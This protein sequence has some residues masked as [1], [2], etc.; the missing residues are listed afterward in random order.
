ME[1]QKL[2]LIITRIKVSI[3]DFGVRHAIWRILEEVLIGK[4]FLYRHYII[5]EKNLTNLESLRI[6]NKNLKF[7]FVSDDDI[8]TLQKIEKMSGLSQDQVSKRLRDCGDCLVAIDNKSVAGVNLITYGI[9]YCPYLHREFAFSESEA[10][11]EQ[12][13]VAPN[14]RRTGI[15]SDLRHIIFH[16]LNNKGYVRLIGGYAPLN[17]R[18]G[19][20]ARKLGFVEREKITYI[21]ILG[22][23]KYSVQQLSP[24]AEKKHSVKRSE[25]AR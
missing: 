8:D 21:K 14:C 6:K 15:A 9:G 18:A 5:Y 16:H 13:T 23:K 19:V 25:H 24:P 2:S 20:L 22:R 1:R 7:V 10:W 3:R 4:L 11:S 12:I 17:V